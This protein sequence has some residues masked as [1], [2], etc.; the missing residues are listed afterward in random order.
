MELI[1]AS[2]VGDGWFYSAKKVLMT[3]KVTGEKECITRAK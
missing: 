1:L 2:A 3:E